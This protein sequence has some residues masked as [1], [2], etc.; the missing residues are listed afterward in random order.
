MWP[1]WHEGYSLNE[2]RPGKW[3]LAWPFYGHYKYVDSEKYTVLWPF[4]SWEKSKKG[5]SLNAP[6]PFY[7]KRESADGKKASVASWPFYSSS[8][9]P[10]KINKSLLWPIASYSRLGDEKTYEERTWILPFYWDLQKVKDGIV[11]EEYQRYWPFMSI[12]K[13]GP[14][15]SI[16]FLSLWPQRNMP[17]I[18][19]NWEAIW[20]LYRFYEDESVVSHDLLWGAGKYRVDRKKD[21]SEFSVFPFVDIK[22]K[23]KKTS[24]NVLKGI[25]G[26]REIN[27][28][29]LEYKVLWF[30]KWNVKR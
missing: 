14:R 18:E 12:D 6:W 16:K 23:D 26:R 9:A 3:F 8:Y 30:L 11:Q 22:N 5:K 13:A 10:G 4:I 29:E 17:S 21:E 20:E 25:V 28:K 7:T 15:K 1:F 24:W 19:R 2:E 27:D